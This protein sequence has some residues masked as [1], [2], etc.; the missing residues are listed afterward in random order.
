VSIN[1]NDMVRAYSGVTGI[2]IDALGGD[3][4]VR[5][6]GL[7]VNALIEGGAGDDT[8]D[9][10]GVA[11]ARV[12]LRGGSGKDRLYGG[13]GADRLDGGDADDELH[14][15]AGDDWLEGG[16]GKDK[17]YGDAGAD[18]LIGGNGDDTVK[19]GAGDD[20]LVR[21]PGHDSLDG[22]SGHNRTIDPA[23]VPSLPV[24]PPIIDWSAA[25]G[26]L[27]M[28]PSRSSWTGD[29]VSAL[30]QSAEERNPNLSIRVVKSGSKA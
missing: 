5:V 23:Q 20:V 11:V 1:V 27:A 10:G 3:D 22:G 19:G 29:F 7:T 30:G 13:A 21:G 18:V 9:A 6:A 2:Q 25:F 4:D 8:I 24:P 15:G 14:G 16:E 26:A 17:L 28:Q 12:E